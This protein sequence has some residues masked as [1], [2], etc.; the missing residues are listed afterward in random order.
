MGIQNPSFL[1]DATISATGGTASTF[2]LD[3]T[4]VAN[5]IG[6]IES[7][8]TDFRTA[9]RLT[10]KSKPSYYVPG[11]KNWVMARQ[12]ATLTHPIILVDGSTVFESWTLVHLGH[13]ERAISAQDTQRGI[14]AQ[15]LFD[16]DLVPFWRNGALNG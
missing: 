6:L 3:A 2:G 4:K 9:R 16:S 12:E 14:A 10:L 13:P 1:V 7:S 15:I 5:G 8:F 11:T